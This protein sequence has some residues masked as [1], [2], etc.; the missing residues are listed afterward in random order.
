MCVYVCMCVCMCVCVCVCVC[1]CVY[2]CVCVYVCM[3][4]C[5]CS[6]TRAHMWHMCAHACG[7]QGLM[8]G[9]ISILFYIIP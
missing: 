3:C 4:V 1:M 6:R 9:V 7:D 5:V 2:V 8:T